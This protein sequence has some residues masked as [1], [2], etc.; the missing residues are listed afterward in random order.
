M[1]KVYDESMEAQINAV[2]EQLRPFLQRD[3]GDISL[4]EV[5]DDKVVRVQLLGACGTC[6]IS[7]QTLKFGVEST[8]KRYIPDIK[9][10]EAV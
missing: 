5:T 9:A 2:L 1:S 3:G 6:D 10:V 8:I 4:V 7:Y